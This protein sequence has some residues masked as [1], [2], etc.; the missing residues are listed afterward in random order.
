MINIP[1]DQHCGSKKEIETTQNVK[2]R[3]RGACLQIKAYTVLTKL[4]SV[5]QFTLT[6]A[7]LAQTWL[8]WL[9]TSRK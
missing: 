5:I 2:G 3:K 4:D 6:K 8:V 7:I 9:P 1:W